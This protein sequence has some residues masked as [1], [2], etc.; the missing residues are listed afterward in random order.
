[1]ALIIGGT[2]KEPF[3]QLNQGFLATL[4][5]KPPKI[6]IFKENQFQNFLEG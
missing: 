3:K 4:I 2:I 5:P 6:G 1:M